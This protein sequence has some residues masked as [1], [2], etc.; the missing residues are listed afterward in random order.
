MKATTLALFGALAAPVVYNVAKGAPA[1]ESDE[2]LPGGTSA[3]TTTGN[4]TLIAGAALLAFGLATDS[5]IASALGAG[6]VF[7]S[8]A[9]HV[10]SL[11][12]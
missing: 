7:A 9:M 8:A 3:W 6:S 4:A 10:R 12:A 1:L 2:Q 11:S 5:K